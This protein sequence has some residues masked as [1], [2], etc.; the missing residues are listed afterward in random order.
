MEVVLAPHSQP[1]IESGLRMDMKYTNTH[2]GK[3]AVRKFEVPLFAVTWMD[4]EII[5]LSEVTQRLYIILYD[6]TYI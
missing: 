1:E 5:T 4:L 2:S 3:L 6:I